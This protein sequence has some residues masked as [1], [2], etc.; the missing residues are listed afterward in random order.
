MQHIEKSLGVGNNKRFQEVRRM[1]LERRHSTECPLVLS[2]LEPQEH[3]ALQK[4]NQLL[5]RKCKVTS[6]KQRF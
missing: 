6:L 4:I 1:H 5:N 3:T 2:S